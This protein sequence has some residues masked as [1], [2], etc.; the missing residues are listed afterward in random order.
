MAGA[1]HAGQTAVRLRP[2]CGWPAAWAGPPVALRQLQCVLL[3]EVRCEV[4][5]EV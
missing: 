3:R 2:K 5:C 4:R 1:A